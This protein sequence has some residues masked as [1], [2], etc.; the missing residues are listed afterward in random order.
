MPDP[1]IVHYWREGIM[2][3]TSW[4]TERRTAV[5]LLRSGRTPSQVATL[6]GRSL[7]W[8]YRCRQRFDQA[9]WAALADRSRAPHHVANRLAAPIQQA[10]RQARSELEARSSQERQ[11]RYIGAHAIQA[12]LR[13]QG[14]TPIP[15]IASIARVVAAAGMTRPKH[16]AVPEVRYPHL[17][18]DQPHTLC[19]V[20]IVP[21]YLLGGQAVACFNAIDVVSHYPTGLASSSKRAQDALAF[22]LQVWRELGVA[23]YTQ[24]DNEA[25]FSGGFT[26]PAVVGQ[27]V[28]LGL[29]V[30]TELLFSPLRHPAS[31]GI[32]ERFHQ[33]Y[34][35]HVWQATELV[36]V[37]AVQ[38][39]ADW[40]LHAYRHSRH[41][42][43]LHGRTPAEVHQS[44][45][46]RLL[47]A[48]FALPDGKLPLQ[49]GRVH[50]L[51]RVSA[52]Q[53]IALLNQTW[54]VPNAQ[55]DQGVWATL[56]FR[57]HGATLN[58]YDTAP[59]APCRT[60]LAVHPF[61]LREGVQEG[62]H[63]GEPRRSSRT[64]L[65]DWL[66]DVVQRHV[67]AWFSTMC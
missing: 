59:D 39:Q 12:R 10:I 67:G 2:T 48:T 25:C 23:H 24:L 60:C 29:Y 54:D 17:Q 1:T 45:P 57:P 46:P 19:Q 31:N 26:H 55:A 51:R 18:P 37:A 11:L 66:V 53:T 7:A 52:S 20:D 35:R 16:P 8:V 38:R 42:E 58:V 61:P 43:A 40:F 33:D 49:T 28:R 63:I 56:T 21:H 47:P 15:S 32:V 44:A 27:V 65:G 34:S 50:F 9:D 22:L 64:W 4:V 30:G 6:L 3:T 36:D 14:L 62:E 13:E 5:H 41:H